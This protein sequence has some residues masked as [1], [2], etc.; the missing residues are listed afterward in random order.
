MLYL[1]NSSNKMEG[2]ES[3][4]QVKASISYAP[5]TGWD[6]AENRETKMDCIEQSHKTQ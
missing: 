3:I 2:V 5:T 1:P 6:N 4:G